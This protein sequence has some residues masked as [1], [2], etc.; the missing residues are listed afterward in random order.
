MLGETDWNRGNFG[1]AEV[2]NSRQFVRID[3]GLSWH[4]GSKLVEGLT[5]PTRRAEMAGVQDIAEPIEPGELSQTIT[6]II[7][8]AE[9]LITR[10]G[11]PVEERLGSYRAFSTGYVAELGESGHYLTGV[12]ARIKELGT[13]ATKGASSTP[14]TTT[15]TTTTSTAT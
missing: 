6:R 4:F 11:T 9:D 2:E 13:L 7:S 15:S 8:T 12:P 1:V 3:F 14:T 5:N 10:T